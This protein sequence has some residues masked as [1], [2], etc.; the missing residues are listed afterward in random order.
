[1]VHIFFYVNKKKIDLY[2]IPDIMENVMEMYPSAEGPH[3]KCGRP[4]NRC[5]GSNPS[6]SVL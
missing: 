2:P 3:S 1:M 5:E 6:I 4:G